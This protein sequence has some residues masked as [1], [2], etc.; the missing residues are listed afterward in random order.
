MRKITRKVMVEWVK[1]HKPG[2]KVN[3]LTVSQYVQDEDEVVYVVIP[4]KEF[5]KKAEDNII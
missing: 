1:E 3:G 4:L 2:T 5:I